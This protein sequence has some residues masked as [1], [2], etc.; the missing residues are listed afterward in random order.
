MWFPGH[1]RSPPPE[2][3]LVDSPPERIRVVTHLMFKQL[4]IHHMKKIPLVSALAMACILVSGCSS[5]VDGGDKSV[6]INSDPAGAK[7]TIFDKEGKPVD[8]RTTPTSINLKRSHGY[9]AGEKY[10]L[11]FEVPGYYSGETYVQ[12]TIDGWYFGNLLFGGLI[13]I[14]IV[15]PAT[16]AMYTLSPRELTYTLLSTNLNLNPEEL[17]AAQ[18]KA[19]PPKMYP[20]ATN[21]AGV[22]K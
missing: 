7:L 15:D 10:K 21:H 2:Y 8:S 13:G 6:R 4:K 12:S 14:L 19:N 9:F 17:K 11:V 1:C 5:I 20:A 22:K 16:G 3:L 18:L